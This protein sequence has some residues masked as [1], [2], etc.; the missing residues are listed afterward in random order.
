MTPR[1]TSVK[2][3]VTGGVRSG[4]SVHAEGL[5]VD[6]ADVV[7]V[8][9]GPVPDG[10]DAA[11]ANRIA[12]H[13]ERRPASW[14]TVES[15][16]LAS[17]LTGDRAFLVDDLSVWLAAQIDQLNGWERPLEDW[18][19]QLQHRVDAAVEA[20]A[21]AVSSVVLVTNEVGLGGVAAHRSAR[22]FADLLGAVNQRFA[23]ICDEVHLVV[24]GRV[25]RLP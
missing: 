19:A 12:A 15:T 10:T 23:N 4:K 22:L 7:Y 20:V 21:R 1:L 18:H 13:R 14:T 17:A 5:M 16:D 24:A 9:P 6:D 2:I 25:L 8:A 11:W 3:L